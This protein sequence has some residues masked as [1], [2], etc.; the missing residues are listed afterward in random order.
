MN[1]DLTPEQDLLAETVQSYLTDKFPAAAIRE[2]VEGAGEDFADLWTGLAALG[3][4]GVLVPE[5]SGGLGLEVLDAAVAAQALGHR[6]APVWLTGHW[7]AGLALLRAGS[8]EQRE[9]WLPR[10]ASGEVR[11]GLVWSEQGTPVLAGRGAQLFVRRAGD[12]L[13]LT[14]AGPAVTVRRLPGIDL[15]RPLDEVTIDGTAEQPLP[16]A[17]AEVVAYLRAVGHV[18]LAADAFGGELHCL[19]SSVE[20]AK[21]RRQRGR[22]IGRFQAVKHQLADLALLVEPGRGLY[23]YAAHT[24]DAGLPDF[25]DATALAKS[26]LAD[27]YY[28]AARAAIELHGGIGYTWECDLHLYLKRALLD[29]QY[30][31]SPETLRQ[32]IADRT[33]TSKEAR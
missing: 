11:A 16:G 31:G 29:R 21:T 6:A 2:R 33:L 8:P 24:L 1:F 15:T 17:N 10:L 26:H 20:Y 30:L 9:S 5:E 32:E 23:W 22:E 14:E 4:P 19:E 18:L 28:R 25:L 27:A 7:L 13:L 3:L 12:E